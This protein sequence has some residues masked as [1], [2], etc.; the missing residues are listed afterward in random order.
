MSSTW[1]A[2]PACGVDMAAGE[3]RSSTNETSTPAE[4]F[5]Q[6]CNRINELLAIR[7]TTLREQVLPGLAAHGIGFVSMS[8]LS[9]EEL[10]KVDEFFESAGISG[11]DASCCRPGTSVSVHLE[12]VAVAR[13]GSA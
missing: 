9:K 6:L 2:W 7:R 3:Q 4:Q 10:A 12:S 13:R 1:C 5:E 8:D 11:A